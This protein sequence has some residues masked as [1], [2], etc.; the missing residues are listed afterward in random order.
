M[1]CRE[2]VIIPINKP[3]IFLEG[4]G[5]NSTSVQWDDHGTAHHTATFDV[6]GNDT[7]VKDITFE[8]LN[9]T[10]VQDTLFDSYGRHY[11]QNCYIQG[12]TDFIFGEGQ[13]I[14]EDCQ[15]YF[16]CGNRRPRR[17]GCIT[18]NERRSADAPGGFVFKNCNINGTRAKTQLGRALVSGNPRVIIANSFLADVIR[19]EGWGEVQRFVGHE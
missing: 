2:K 18:A 19:P 3:C 17:D 14:F 13:S 5:R 8:V 9:T 6:T 10:R 11:Y 16:T 4:A 1:H 15:I 12:H 7:I